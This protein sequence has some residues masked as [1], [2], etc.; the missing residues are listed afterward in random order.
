MENNNTQHELFKPGWWRNI[1]VTPSCWYWK[2][3]CTPQGYGRVKT[4]YPEEKTVIVHRYVYELLVGEIP[5]GLH[6]DHK[7]STQG[8]PRNCVNPT[9]LI[10]ATPKQNAENRKRAKSR[11]QNV[12]KNI[13]I[14]ASGTY[15]VVV[16]SNGIYH[17]GGTHKQ[18]DNAEKAAVKLRNEVFTH[19]FDDQMSVHP[20]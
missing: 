12:E 13:C 16:Y 4:P 15:R 1:E 11:T 5:K 10:P 18:L 20:S 19:N 8:C 9:H 17:Y 14:T 3:Y 7:Y 2:G 6:L